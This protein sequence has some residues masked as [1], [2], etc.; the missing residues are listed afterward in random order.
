MCIH[1]MVEWKVP[2]FFFSLMC[3]LT[4]SGVNPAGLQAEDQPTVSYLINSDTAF[5]GQAVLSG[6]SS[7]SRAAP[8]SAL[9]VMD[10]TFSSMTQSDGAMNI[11]ITLHGAGK[12]LSAQ[13]DK[14]GDIVRMQSL[15]LSGEPVAFDEEDRG[16]LKLLARSLNPAFDDLTPVRERLAVFAN[17]MIGKFPSGVPLDIHFIK[18]A[19]QP[20]QRCWELGATTIALLGTGFVYDIVN[21][22]LD[23]W[24]KA[25]HWTYDSASNSICGLG[26]TPICDRIGSIYKD[27]AG[28]VTTLPLDDPNNAKEKPHL[29]TYHGNHSPVGVPVKYSAE[30]NDDFCLGRCGPG[31]FGD[32]T[33]YFNSSYFTVTAECFA[34]DVCIGEVGNDSSIPAGGIGNAC[35]DEFI[36]ASW[37]YLNG[38]P[39]NSISKTDVLDWWVL[40]TDFYLLTKQV[41]ANGLYVLQQMQNDNLVPIGVYSLDSNK[42]KERYLTA[43]EF[44]GTDSSL[45]HWFY[46]G[47]SIPQLW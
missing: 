29:T 14:D 6:E 31:C 12:I 13:V 10:C 24:L 3:V 9:P 42:S 4:I 41:S 21:H 15:T 45:V 1:S 28:W 46:S 5:S 34:H 25:R 43:M 40:N 26:Y 32:I 16:Q 22:N 11:S 44:N 30:V 2:L 39:C 37:G 19:G 27:K 18:P 47:S 36:N 35:M 17:F 38:A 20:S 33:D 23:A 8:A 7:G